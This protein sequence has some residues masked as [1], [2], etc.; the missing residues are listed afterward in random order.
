[1]AQ[2][3]TRGSGVPPLGKAQQSARRA[4][5]GTPPPIKRGVPW[6]VVATVTALVVGGGGILAYAVTNQGS[7]FTDPLEAADKDVAG[8]ARYDGLQQGHRDGVLNYPQ[9]PP[10]GGPHN[11]VWSTCEGNV[12]GAPVAKENAAHSL[13]HGAVWV[14]YRPDL[15]KADVA[16][17]A[18]LVEGTSYRLM[19]PY[20]GLKDAISLQAWGR[21]LK[22][23][24]VDTKRAESFLKA[25]TNGPQAPEKGAT[26]SG[27]T[28]AT[29]A[30]PGGA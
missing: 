6:G 17:L 23:A 12:Y 3:P 2:R 20:P 19:S 28:Q 26:C 22:L 27:G 11:G 4:R 21:Q 8:V 10:A 14:T 9:D 13:E 30:V 29:G 16:K 24:S 1:M 7:G 15:P 25:Y 5:R 18:G